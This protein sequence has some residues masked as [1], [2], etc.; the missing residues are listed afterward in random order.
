MA[1]VDLDPERG[2]VVAAE[3]KKL[4]VAKGPQIDAAEE[5]YITELACKMPRCFCPAELGGPTHFEPVTADW[6]DWRSD[7]MPTHE[8]SPV[9][10][11]DGGR[12]TAENTVLA[13]RLCNRLDF[14]LTSGRSHASDLA[15]IER[16]REEALRRAES[17]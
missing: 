16:A 6:S 7:W 4:G 12:R 5:G 10:K 15:R 14:S 2:R 1:R 8:H 17:S 11:R 9:P 13:H 3:L